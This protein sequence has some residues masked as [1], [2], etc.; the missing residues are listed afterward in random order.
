MSEDERCWFHK[1]LDDQCP[2]AGQ[3]HW[4]QAENELMRASVWCSEH[5]HGNDERIRKE[6]S[7][8]R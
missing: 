2:N 7:H 4:P 6:S 1:F 5:K 3:W 8:D